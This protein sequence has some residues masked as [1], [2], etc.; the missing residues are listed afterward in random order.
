[1]RPARAHAE[2]IRRTA[3]AHSSR[4]H[5][6][7]HQVDREQLRPALTRDT[8]SNVVGALLLL[9]S[10][11]PR[12][13][14]G[15]AEPGNGVQDR[16]IVP[17]WLAVGTDRFVVAVFEV[18][19][20][21]DSHRFGAGMVTEQQGGIVADDGG[22][23]LPGAGGLGDQL[24]DHIGEAPTP[25]QRAALPSGRRPRDQCCMAQFAHGV[26]V[27]ALFELRAQRVDQAADHLCGRPAGRAGHV[28][29]VALQPR[30][31]GSPQRGSTY[32]RRQECR[33]DA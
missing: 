33:R 18:A 14:L 3:A 31:C 22:A 9:D 20:G 27:T 24:I 6:S 23:G 13:Q 7:R 28:D 19:A 16:P 4:S 2:P 29:Q 17:P 26:P 12:P 11:F 25:A 8:E 10:R 15:H 5:H 30:P 21:Q 32:R 1:M